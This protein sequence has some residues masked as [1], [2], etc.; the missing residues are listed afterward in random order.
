MVMIYVI[1]L[2]LNDEDVKFCG[3]HG[4]GGC[5]I[6]EVDFNMEFE[7]MTMYKHKSGRKKYG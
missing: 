7:I 4:M 6:T 2:E 1:N 3:V 5:D